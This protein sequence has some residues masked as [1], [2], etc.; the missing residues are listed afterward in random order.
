ME[1]E[2]CNVCKGRGW[3]L[4]NFSDNHRTTCGKC[5]GSG[6]QCA[7]C[8]H[9]LHKKGDCPW[10]RSSGG[11]MSGKMRTVEYCHCES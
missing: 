5:G 2:D 7:G 11:G 9:A 4:K 1:T 10:S 6:R 3:Y 8:G